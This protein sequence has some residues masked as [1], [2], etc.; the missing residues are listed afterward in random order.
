MIEAPLFPGYIFV[1]SS[2][3]SGD[4]V[5]VLKTVGAVQLLGNHDGPLPVPDF[6]IESLKIIISSNV[7]LSSGTN[8]QLRQGD[9]V[10]II[11]GPLAGVRGEFIQYKGK[12]HVVV[13][14]EALGQ[15]VGTEIEKNKVEKLPD[16][17]I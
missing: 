3:S 6:Q 9:P 5:N 7:N 12:S 15:Y 8:V 13:R 10:M 4:Q 2:F 11:E 17:L 1:Q 16:I 14:V